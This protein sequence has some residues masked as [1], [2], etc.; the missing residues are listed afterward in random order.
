MEAER[1]VLADL[2]GFLQKAESQDA[3]GMSNA[4]SNL[5]R[6]VLHAK[7]GQCQLSPD[8]SA[9]KQFSSAIDLLISTKKALSKQASE[10]KDELWKLCPSLPAL[11]SQQAAEPSAAQ[12]GNLPD[13]R[14]DF[15]VSIKG[16]EKNVEKLHRALSQLGDMVVMS[17]QDLTRTEG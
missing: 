1:Q 12:A 3:D 17:E 16:A 6:S 5:R 4:F 15:A 13:L 7:Q 14:S 9:M 10:V 8:P 2:Q 11:G